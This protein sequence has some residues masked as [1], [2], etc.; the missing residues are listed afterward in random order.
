MNNI[1]SSVEAIAQEQ[2]RSRVQHVTDPADS[3]RVRLDPNWREPSNDGELT[4]ADLD[5]ID[6]EFRQPDATSRAVDCLKRGFLDSLS[7]H[8]VGVDHDGFGPSGKARIRCSCGWSGPERF[9]W[10]DDMYA[11]LAADKAGHLAQVEADR[12]R[13][14]R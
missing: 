6:A 5:S 9:E 2:P 3:S 12:S 7:V 14:Q 1:D 8:L 4:Q 10:Q 11:G 13:W